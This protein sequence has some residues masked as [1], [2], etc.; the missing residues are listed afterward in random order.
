MGHTHIRNRGLPVICLVDNFS[1]YVVAFGSKLQNWNWDV[2]FKKWGIKFVLTSGSIRTNKW[3]YVTD[4]G[5][6]IR[7]NNYNPYWRNDSF[8][9]LDLQYPVCQL[10]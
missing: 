3:L 8:L 1:H 6:T 9:S 2:Y 4:N 7:N 5:Y 10:Y